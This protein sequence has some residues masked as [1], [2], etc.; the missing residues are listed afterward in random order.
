MRV[1]APRVAW[2]ELRRAVDSYAASRRVV[3][4][5]NIRHDSEASNSNGNV[6]YRYV[7]VRRR[8]VLLVVG[9]LAPGVVSFPRS[10]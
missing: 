8:V 9:S 5:L 7:N 10:L 6:R 2:S 3:H 1:E 4:M